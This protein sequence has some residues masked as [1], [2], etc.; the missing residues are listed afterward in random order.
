M[1]YKVKDVVVM[2]LGQL[3][4]VEE[5]QPLVRQIRDLDL[6]VMQNTRSELSMWNLSPEIIEHFFDGWRKAGLEVI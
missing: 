6:D 5:A 1:V 2:C 4:K 3:G